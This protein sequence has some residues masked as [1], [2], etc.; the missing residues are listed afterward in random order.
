MV[1]MKVY[2]VGSK[3]VSGAVNSPKV[4]GITTAKGDRKPD[5]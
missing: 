3:K 4:Q 1:Y 5:C 2:L